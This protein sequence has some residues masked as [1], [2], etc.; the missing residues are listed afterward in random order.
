MRL[1]ILI[2][3]RTM[4]LSQQGVLCMHQRTLLVCVLCFLVSSS[5]TTA[6]VGTAEGPDMT[7]A[8]YLLSD[9]DVGQIVIKVSAVP[10]NPLARD[11]TITNEILVFEKLNSD[12]WIFLSGSSLFPGERKVRL[13]NGEEQGILDFIGIDSMRSFVSRK[14]VRAVRKYELVDDQMEVY[15]QGYMSTA[16]TK[17]GGGI[18]FDRGK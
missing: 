9:E 3:R 5:A 1:S 7:M 15:L 6:A 11:Y 18:R 17:N 4:E 8:E 13:L 2:L 16:A 10:G 12:Q 14:T